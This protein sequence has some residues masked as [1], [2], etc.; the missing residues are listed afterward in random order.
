MYKFVVINLPKTFVQK[1][2]TSNCQT[3][4]HKRQLYYIL[5]E[6]DFIFQCCTYSHRVRT[7]MALVSALASVMSQNVADLGE[8]AALNWYVNKKNCCT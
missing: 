3:Q 5:V 8:L 2:E 6:V 7:E 4:T 1:Y